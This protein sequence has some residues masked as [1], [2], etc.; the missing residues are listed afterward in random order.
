MDIAG[1]FSADVDK[2]IF[3]YIRV[4]TLAKLHFFFFFLSKV[5]TGFKQEKTDM[6]SIPT[7]VDSKI[8][9]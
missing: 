2:F 4:Y 5:I 6:T 8:I 7:K 3:R 1:K 9:N